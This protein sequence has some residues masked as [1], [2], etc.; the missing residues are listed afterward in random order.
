MIYL[1]H[2]ATTPVETTVL[3]TMLPYFHT[4]FGNAGS[5]LHPYG[6]AAAE[7]IKHARTQVAA[8]LLAEP[9]ELL[10]TSG[11]TES[12]NLAIKGV[13]QAYQHKGRHLVTV[14][15][16]HKAVLEAHAQLAQQGW[17]VEYLPTDADGILSPTVFAHALRSETVLASVMWANNETGV[18][19]DLPIL[20]QIAREKG[21]LLFSDATQA[22]GKVPISAH[23]ADLLA[24][25]GHKMY[26]PKGIGALYVRRRNPRVSL[27]PQIIGGGQER[28]MRGG[29]L[30]TPGI[31]ALGKAAQIAQTTLQTT[32]ERIQYLRD[33][34][35]SQLLEQLPAVTVHGASVPRLP[36]TLSF[37]VSGIPAITWV[38]EVRQVAFSTGSACTTAQ[39]KPSHVLTAL[40]L[41]RTS[42]LET[43][44]ISLG[45][46]TTPFEIE[47]TISHFITA[48]QK[49]GIK[50]H[51]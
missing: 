41:D 4:H 39:T 20:Y 47:Q 8:L 43:I 26:A 25:S 3:E 10:F 34:L 14:Q 22:A 5:N 45:R 48:A 18:L 38:K 30:N 37:R 49:L 17:K 23:H 24:I 1:D 44:R 33:L 42:A 46:P 36:N 31:V 15:T 16:E 9:E 50:P 6:W 11:A 40:G 28:G 51:I 29:T 21:V 19:Q 2:N 7:A 32:S 13:A 35:E 12:V 27:L